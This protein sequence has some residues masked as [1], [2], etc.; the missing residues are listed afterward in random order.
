MRL[1]KWRRL[2][3]LLSGFSPIVPLALIPAFKGVNGG[4]R[5]RGL[6]PSALGDLLELALVEYANT[7]DRLAP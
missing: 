7:V 3:R 6:A 1:G 2:G 5:L 4:R